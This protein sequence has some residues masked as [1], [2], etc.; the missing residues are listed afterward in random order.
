[1]K[2][3]SKKNVYSYTPIYEGSNFTWGEATKNCSRI[4]EKLIIDGKIIL[5]ALEVEQTIIK[6]AKQLDIVRANLGGRPIKVNS[7]YRPSGVNA[8]VGGS[9]WSRHQYGDGVDI[10]SDYISSYQLYKLLNKLHLD[11]GLGRYT[12]FVHIDFRG[13]AARWFG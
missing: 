12:S 2:L 1:M 8:R 3:P 9:T 5:S 6:T 13:E 7:W 4:P 11:G 10:R